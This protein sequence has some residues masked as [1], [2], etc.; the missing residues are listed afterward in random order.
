MNK[1][2][3]HEGMTVWSSDGHKL[4]KVVACEDRSFE[5]EK[6]FFFPKEYVVTYDEI[7]ELRGDNDLVLGRSR[8]ELKTGE[9]EYR[10]PPRAA[11]TYAQPI[12]REGMPMG[13]ETMPSER[14]GL[15]EEEI[16]VPLTEEQIRAQKYTE[17][18]GKVQV[19]K[20]VV[21]EER[22]VTVP[23]QKEV[24]RVERVPAGP[25]VRATE[26]SFERKVEEM[27]IREEKVEITKEP[28]VREEL[29]VK[30][31]LVG[32]AETAGET[33]RREEAHVETTGGMPLEER[34]RLEG[35][36]IE[37]KSQAVGGISP[38]VGGEDISKRK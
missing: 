8:N 25:D 29:R 13:R 7:T 5:I 26:P 17:E 28:V 21:T 18:V 2:D 30:K 23:V 20:D 37:H 14:A 33:V 4:G 22:Q 38:P 6:G 19:T 16:R 34:A 27:P 11:E 31:E 10:E 32:G 1:G 15:A 36:R 12:G 35:E 24:V 9:A 3:I